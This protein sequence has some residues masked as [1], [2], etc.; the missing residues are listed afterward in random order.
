MKVIVGLGNPG[1]EYSWTRHNV[2]FMMVDALA[3][4]LD[5]TPWRCK[6]DAQIAEAR[7][8]GESVLL[9]KPQTYMNLS[10]GAVGQIV[11]WYKLDAADVIA[12][13]DDMDIPVGMA[14]LRKRGSSGGHRGVESML[15]HLGTE[16]F[17]RVR[18]GIG[19]PAPG[20]KVVDHVLAVPSP[21][22][23]GEIEEAIAIL[24][25]AIECI[26]KEGIEKAMNRYS[27]KPKKQKAM[28]RAGDE[29]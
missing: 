8:G 9:V 12:I 21:K 23:R 14:R 16:E 20:W 22:E 10:G 5:A 11:R 3:E 29:E 19:R 18:I 17:G 7:I 4:R 25:P 6:F 26:V 2:G 1:Q 13:Y 27:F 28:A 24:L 15:A